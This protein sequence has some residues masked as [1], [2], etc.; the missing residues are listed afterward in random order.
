MITTNINSEHDDLGHIHIN[1]CPVFDRTGDDSPFKVYDILLD[2]GVR[3]AAYYR[4]AFHTLRTASKGDIINLLINNGGGYMN[5]AI[6]FRNLI[7]ETEATVIGIL[8]GDTHSAASMI[9]LSCDCV[10]VRPYASMMIHHCSF[11]SMGTVQ[12]VMDHVY[13]TSKLTERLVRDIYKDFLSEPEIE[14][15]IKNKEIWLTDEEI[16]A[17]L[18]VMYANRES[19]E[20]TGEE[21]AEP[22]SVADILDETVTASVQKAFDTLLKKYNLTEKPKKVR[23]AKSKTNVDKIDDD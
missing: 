8:E 13:F 3:E 2:E 18:Q 16:I 22:R 19:E 6:C 10:V 20:G 17:R 21:D 15:V 23:T 4:E 9:A 1:Q 11:G 12:N 7:A 14:D 5:T